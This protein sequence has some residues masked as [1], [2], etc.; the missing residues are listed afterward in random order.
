MQGDVVSVVVLFLSDLWLTFLW[1]YLLHGKMVLVFKARPWY[2]FARAHCAWFFFVLSC[3]PWFTILC[4]L[5]RCI[6]F[7][8]KARLG[9]SCVGLPGVKCFM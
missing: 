8:A 7:L 6:W 4:S 5:M 1:R 3:W 9:Y 2:S